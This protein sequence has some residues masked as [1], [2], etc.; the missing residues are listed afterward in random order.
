[1]F[2]LTEQQKSQLPY[3]IFV[4][5]QR[6]L[7]SNKVSFESTVCGHR[8]KNGQRAP[9]KQMQKRPTSLLKSL[10]VGGLE[11]KCFMQSTNTWFY[12]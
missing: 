4:L 8:Q 3:F 6:I 7:L 1:M 2:N 9:S 12:I 10:R 11:E 5:E